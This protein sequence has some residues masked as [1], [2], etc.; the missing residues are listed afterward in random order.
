MFVVKNCKTMFLKTVSP[1]RLV[2]EHTQQQQHNSKS[3]KVVKNRILSKSHFQSTFLVFR[4]G[5][6]IPFYRNPI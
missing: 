3:E 5:A 2:Q 6:E 1:P 4:F